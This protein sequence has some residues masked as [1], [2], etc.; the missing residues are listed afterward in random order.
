MEAGKYD[1]QS[2][3]AFELYGRH[4]IDL[5]KKSSD[6]IKRLLENRISYFCDSTLETFFDLKD[7]QIDEYC[8][9]LYEA[10][11]NIPRTLGHILSFCYDNA[12]VYDKQINKVTI[13]E[14]IENVYDKITKTYFGKEYKSLGVYEEKIDI[15]SQYQLLD[16]LCDKSLE[17][18]SELPRTGNSHFSALEYA[19]SSHFQVALNLASF[20]DSLEL[21]GLIH[22]VSILAQKGARE[23]QNPDAFIYS[24]DYGLCLNKK[25]LYGRPERSTKY[26]KYYQQRRF[27]YSHSILQ[28][29]SANK[30]IICKECKAEYDISELPNIEKFHMMCEKC[31][32]KSCEIVYNQ[33]LK[34]LV[35]ENL[36]KALYQKEELDVLHVIGLFNDNPEIKLYPLVIGQ[37]M[38]TT[39][40]S[41]VRI[42]KELIE[43]ELLTREI[44]SG[45][46]N[47]PYYK[48]TTRGKEVIQTI[49]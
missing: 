35:L 13:L 20:L 2:I 17:L 22:K 12:I 26:T 45:N 1:Y 44:D 28:S 24:L 15:Y 49:F 36:D 31:G 23:G 7:I 30:R 5:E 38:D 27:D 33:Q 41:V 18:K 47:R 39:Y 25:I 14:A 6:F 29:L 46:R 16:S 9:L 42:A 48:L 11:I 21:N 34:D 19:Y 3:D 32:Q 8:L 43:V 4:Y 40:Q 37:E 10:T